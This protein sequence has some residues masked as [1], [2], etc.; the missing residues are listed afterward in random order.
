[1]PATFKEYFALPFEDP[2]VT[3]SVSRN[4]CPIT[5]PNGDCFI[6][7]TDRMGASKTYEVKVYDP[8]NTSG[9]TVYKFDETGMVDFPLGTRVLFGGKVVNNTSKESPQ[10]K[11]VS[12]VSDETTTPSKVR[13]II[14]AYNPAVQFDPRTNMINLFFWCNMNVDGK[15]VADKGNW[16]D[17]T[18]ENIAVYQGLNAGFSTSIGSVSSMKVVKVLYCAQGY[19]KKVANLNGSMS[20]VEIVGDSGVVIADPAIITTKVNS[21]YYIPIFAQPIAVNIPKKISSDYKADV[22]LDVATQTA[23]EK[24]FEIDSYTIK[25]EGGTTNVTLSIKNIWYQRGVTMS[26]Y[27]EG[28]T[29]P[30]NFSGSSS[31]TKTIVAKIDMIN[32]PVT[33][34]SEIGDTAADLKN[35]FYTKY[36]YLIEVTGGGLTKKRDYR[37]SEINA[38]K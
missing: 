14:E 23:Q 10:M 29:L 35:G 1:M 15:G 24:D 17:Y 12:Y 18:I 33:I 30:V 31:F 20:N 8:T 7:Y 6:F 36:L 38:I 37:G 21:A 25:T 2:S 32:G 26:N 34:A 5:L 3:T 16:Y 4:V 19:F 27:V 13:P 22:I 9:K 11:W 28:T